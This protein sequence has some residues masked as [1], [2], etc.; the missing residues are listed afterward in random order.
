LLCGPVKKLI[1]ILFVFVMLLQAIP[2]LHFFSSQKEVFYTYVDE[3]K[4]EET[5]VVKNKTEAKALSSLPT[6]ITFV[7]RQPLKHAALL[8]QRL[9]SPYIAAHLQPPDAASC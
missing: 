6:I 9:P 7:D 3:D 1:A 4:P 5:K 2:V 8:K